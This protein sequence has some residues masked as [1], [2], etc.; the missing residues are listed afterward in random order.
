MNLGQ[1]FADQIT[2]KL[3]PQL[4]ITKSK[5]KK[6]IHQWPNEIYEI[7]ISM[8]N[9]ERL[10]HY[11][12]QLPNG[13][14]VLEFNL[15]SNTRLLDISYQNKNHLKFQQK[16]KKMLNIVYKDIAEDVNYQQKTQFATID[17]VDQFFQSM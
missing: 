9:D 14:G 6:Y 15:D 8:Q 13:E 12:Y 3:D 1:L 10:D 4:H 16:F 5:L 11:I 17:E 7:I 2:I